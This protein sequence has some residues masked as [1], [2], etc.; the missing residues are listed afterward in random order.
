VITEWIVT[1]ALAIATWFST[2][3]PTWDI[4]DWFTGLGT[5]INGLFAQSGV[6]AFA[7]WSAVATIAA[8]PMLLWAGGLLFK[9]GRLFLSHVPF[10]GG[11]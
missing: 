10:F 4:P 8:V 11:K 7:D 3:L 9:L 6:G 5:N 2:L 1:V